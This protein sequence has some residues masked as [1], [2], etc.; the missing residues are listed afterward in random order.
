[1]GSDAEA[2]KGCRCKNKAAKVI[3]IIRPQ[4]IGNVLIAIYKGTIGGW[5]S[6]KML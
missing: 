5:S 1:M 4:M 6:S 2:D 3:P